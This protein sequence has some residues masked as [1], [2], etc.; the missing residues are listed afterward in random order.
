VFT[1]LVLVVLTL[2][3]PEV[4]ERYDQAVKLVQQ[5]QAAAAEN[6]MREAVM[7]FPDEAPLWRL[8]GVTQA[9][10]G[11]LNDAVESFTRACNLNA[12]LPDA[13]YYLGRALYSVNRF[14]DAIDPLKK[15]IRMDPVKARSETALAE[16]YEALGQSA[17]AE[18]FFR[19][20]IA[21]K[22]R[23]YERALLAYARFLIRAGRTEESLAPIRKA[24]DQNGNSAEAHF[25]W[26]RVHLQTG[27]LEP[28]LR[29]AERAVALEGSN[30]QYRLL[31]ARIY[32][33]L[34]RDDDAEREEKAAV[35]LTAHQP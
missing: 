8:L 2:K 12:S 25:Q 6:L 10:Q 4:Q 19:W 31:L 21:R 14:A 30:G 11:R 33:R 26:A 35:P 7:K 29:S 22:D 23:A 27:E 17:E 3:P 13:C 1:L 9:Q 18:Q 5:G 16:C 20:A 34:G 24:L 32:R 15:A 28:A